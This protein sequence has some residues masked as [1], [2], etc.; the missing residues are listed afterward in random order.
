MT[1][2]AAVFRGVPTH[3]RQGSLGAA[4]DEPTI[5]RLR[6]FVETEGYET[7]LRARP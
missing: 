2:R 6:A 7:I 3:S 5:E 1:R 4:A